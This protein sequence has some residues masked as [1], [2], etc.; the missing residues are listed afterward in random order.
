[1]DA[2]SLLL[3][4]DIRCFQL[5]KVANINRL[6]LVVPCRV[7]RAEQSMEPSRPLPWLLLVLLSALI[8]LASMVITVGAGKRRCSL[9]DYR[10]G[11]PKQGFICGAHIPRTLSLVCGGSYRSPGKRNYGESFLFSSNLMV[12]TH[13]NFMSINA[14]ST[15]FTLRF[16]TSC[17]FK[18]YAILTC[19]ALG[20]YKNASFI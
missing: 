12:P 19:A 17:V 6:I 9:D 13:G 14:D 2:A 1:M 4:A 16:F 20:H 3:S 8:M 5:K 11:A 15:Y 18:F 7:L 10:A